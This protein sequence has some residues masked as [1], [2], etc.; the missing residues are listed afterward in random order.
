M[1]STPAFQSPVPS[2][3][4]AAFGDGELAVSPVAALAP[5]PVGTSY[6][7][8]SFNLKAGT[9]EF[10]VGADDAATLW[11]GSDLG[12]IRRVAAT[13]PNSNLAATGKM[14]ITSGTYRVDV[15][16]RNIALSPAYFVL[17]I[18]RDGVLVY[19]SS[20]AG[21]M[22]SSSPVA[23][24]DLPSDGDPNL[25]LPVLT[26]TPNWDNGVT[27]RLSWKTEVFTSETGAEQRRSIRRNPHRSLE[28]Q[29][30]RAGTSRMRLDSFIAGVG[31]APFLA[32]LWHE[33]YRI[34]D[35]LTSVEDLIQFPAG[36]LRFRE[37]FV[38]D[39]ALLCAGDPDVYEV[40]RVASVN[41]ETDVLTLEFPPSIDWP[42]D[43]RIT[44][45][46]VAR[47]EQ[48]PA[49]D[50]V[51]DRAAYSGVRVDLVNSLRTIDP[52]WGYC[53]PLWRFKLDRSTA[54]TNTFSRNIFT[55][56][57]GS[58]SVDVVDPGQRT[59]IGVKGA[60]KLFGM[61]RVRA[62]R[63]FAAM[64]RG[65]AVRFWFPSGTHDVEPVSVISGTNFLVEP[66]GFSDYMQIPQDA[67]VMLAFEFLDGRP[68]IFRKIISIEALGADS[69][70]YK[71]INER[72]TVDVPLPTIDRSEIE[73]V[74]FVLPV[75]FDQDTF[76]IHHHVSSGK[77]AS[78]A[79]VMMSAEAKDM[80]PLDCWVTSWTYPVIE[81]E[82][83]AVSATL[84]GSGAFGIPPMMESLDIGATIVAGSILEF[85]YSTTTVGPEELNVSATVVAGTI[86]EFINSTTTMEPEELNAA[87]TIVAGALINA[88][89]TYQIDHEDLNISATVLQGTLS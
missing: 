4:S 56:D 51:T 14:F 3:M 50:N 28:A 22:S 64:A 69:P 17:S 29:M 42:A 52:S 46:H 6:L 74:S 19:S 2:P 7:A 48:M 38:G 86:I 45:L 70:P 44:P 18:W 16:L 53:A 23:D 11:V 37:F 73:R 58:T 32:P 83:I 57:V 82:E 13:V 77:A 40:V 66:R 60:L 21:W 49:M 15:V 39:L 62:F 34:R 59:R 26:V 72:F 87:A 61:E 47:F 78:A 30:L 88:L 9:Y 84:V 31:S 85:I 63:A 89:I 76:E 68:T 54:I 25:L 35:Q 27:E 65:R 43:T 8:R 24:V 33:Q 36:T 41:H 55:L 10:K 20:A 75:R 80:P 81:V 71:T 5:M 67:R 12:S 1:P 79:V